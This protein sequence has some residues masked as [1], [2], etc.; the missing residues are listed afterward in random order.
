MR[1]RCLDCV[2][3][4]VKDAAEC[5]SDWTLSPYR[6]AKRINMSEVYREQARARAKNSPPFKTT[7]PD[8]P[9]Q[10]SKEVG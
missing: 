3:G 5:K 1:G 7:S 10:T 4:S 2:C 6:F 8:E 9:V